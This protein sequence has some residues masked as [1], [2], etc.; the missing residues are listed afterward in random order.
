VTDAHTK[1]HGIA[2]GSRDHLAARRCPVELWTAPA[3]R[4]HLGAVYVIAQGLIDRVGQ[5]LCSVG[6]E[7]HDDTRSRQQ[8]CQYLEIERDLL[9]R[10]IAAELIGHA[11]D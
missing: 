5:P 3:D 4:E 2:Q 1:T 7:V 9:I 11:A 8:T 10:G 6:R